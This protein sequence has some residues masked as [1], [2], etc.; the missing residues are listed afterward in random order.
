MP[1]RSLLSDPGPFYFILGLT[2][3]SI[4]FQVASS[5][6]EVMSTLLDWLSDS[7]LRFTT[8]DNILKP[9]DRVASQ[10]FVQEK[11]LKVLEHLI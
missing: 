4:T 11:V 10:E 8:I 6:Y 1:L 9:V 2:V 3:F 5:T 7:Q